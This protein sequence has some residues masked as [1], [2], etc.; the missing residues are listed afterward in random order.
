MNIT[1]TTKILG[2]FGYPVSHTLSP[3]M[4][5]SAS[6][7]LGLNYTYLPFLVKPEDLKEAVQAIRA[8]NF[9]GVNVTVPHKEKVIPF[10]DVLDKEASL[11]GAVNTIVNRDGN[12]HGYNTDGRGFIRSLEE[13]GLSPEGIKALIIGAGGASRAIAFSL[14]LSGASDIGLFDI[15]REKAHSLVQDIQNEKFNS[16]QITE[17]TS[18]K[19]YQLII[20]ATPLGLKEGDPLPLEP[21]LIMP[22]MFIYDAIYKKTPLLQEAEKK[23]AQ[24]TEGSGMLLWQGVLAF[25]L[26]TSKEPPV[27]V[28]R[29]ALYKGMGK[30]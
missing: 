23:G 9:N 2:L 4:H 11:I 17:I 21:D 12:L 29:E 19:K 6:D 14:A 16:H 7:S 30:V 26:W 5:N 18:V 3:A 20:N 27:E 25:Q 28:M 1:G 15:D 8:L 10:L 24:G 22:G 13:S